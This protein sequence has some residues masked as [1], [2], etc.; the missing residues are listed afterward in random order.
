M[1]A[2]EAKM[3]LLSPILMLVIFGGL[4]LRGPMNLPEA[5]RPLLPLA[6]LAMILFALVQLVG[7]QFGFDRGGFRVFV[8]GPARRRDILLGKNL[9]VAFLA[10]VLATP[11]VVLVEVVFP[12]R[13]DQLL[14]LLPQAVT[15]YLLFCLAANAMS[16]LAPVPM[17][18][19]SLKPASPRGLAVLL[20]IL[21][22]FA[23]PVALAPSLIPVG[24][25]A[26]LAAL[27]WA[28]G[29]PVCLLLSVLEGV[30]MVYLYGLV[31]T[32]QGS[33]LQAREQCILQIVAARAE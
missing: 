16:I 18:M 22:V 2:P 20:H 31:L 3:I 21:F 28:Q 30:A 6:G 11:V 26:L 15:M 32:W 9:A 29:W 14:A 25:E 19:G 4:F 10:V 7:N 17:A 1:R 27:G 33:W 8:L 23:F 13:L 24:I 12:L 5:A